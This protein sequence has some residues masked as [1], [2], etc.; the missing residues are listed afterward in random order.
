MN[1]HAPKRPKTC[2]TCGESFVATRYMQKFCS[3]L[4]VPQVKRKVKPVAGGKWG[5]TA[6]GEDRCRRCGRPAWELHHIV[7]R[8]RSRKL[9]DDI[10]HNGIPLCKLCHDGWHAK[11]VVITRSCLRESEIQVVRAEMGDGWLDRHY[12]DQ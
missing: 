7:P 3:P 6:K 2:P 8:S 12:P 4:C 10:E 9:R 1:R 5:V 11:T